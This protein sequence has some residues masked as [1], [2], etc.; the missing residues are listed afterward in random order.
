MEVFNSLPEDQLQEIEDFLTFIPIYNSKR[1]EKA[2]YNLLRKYK[3]SIKGKVCCE[4][5]AGRGI[6]SQF[7]AGQGASKVY[8]VERSDAMLKILDNTLSERPE[9][10][11]VPG[12]IEDLEPEEQIDLL[13]H[14][15]YGPLV[16][17]ETIFALKDLSF[18]PKMVLPDGGRL[19]AMPLS[20]E[21]IREKV[22]YYDPSWKEVLKG[23]LISEFVHPI[24]F[25]AKW[26]V[27]DWD[28]NSKQ[29]EFEFEVPED[30][31]YL[32]FCGEITHQGNSV[33]KMWW[34][35]NWPLIFTPV[36]GNR[37]QIRFE[38]IDGFTDVYFD[39]I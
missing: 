23:V 3:S 32:V 6:L 10:E 8:A 12:Y 28:I 13:I 7:M 31:D 35:N 4:A 16:L 33:L 2:Y 24:T 1:R 11:I 20:E 30:C 29:E 39:W 34:T 26:K 5:G 36:N 38:Y 9:I 19:W 22:S 21:T 37:F 25:E 18:V 17:D 27:F 14:E 15:F